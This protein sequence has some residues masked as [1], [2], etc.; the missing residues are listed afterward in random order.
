MESHLL[1]DTRTNSDTH[2]KDM[3]SEPIVETRNDSNNSKIR[4]VT[5]SGVTSALSIIIPAKINGCAT[6]VV[7]DSAAQVTVLS[8][9][10]VQSMRDPPKVTEN[11]WLKGAGQGQF[12]SA[13]YAEGVSFVIGNHTYN[14]DI[15][16]A[17]ISDKVI[18]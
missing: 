12:M 11:V 4:E 7:V 3:V 14:W 15:Y 9:E 10:F 1:H 16:V 17:P 13:K 6:D 18:L 8:E 2:T 5:F